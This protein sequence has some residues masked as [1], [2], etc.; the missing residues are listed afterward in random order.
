MPKE[1]RHGDHIEINWSPEENKT[2]QMVLDNQPC[3]N[4]LNCSRLLVVNSVSDCKT[5]EQKV[6]KA[7]R[8]GY[9]HLTSLSNREEVR[10]RA[11][12]WPVVGGR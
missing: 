1:E 6:S 3:E 4:L 2:K 8:A 10:G 11:T 9:N 5:I 7:V 12:W